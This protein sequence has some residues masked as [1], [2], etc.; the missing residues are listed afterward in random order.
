MK[1]Y[2]ECCS[3]V[4]IKHKLGKSLVTG[5]KAGYWEEAAE[6]YALELRK[7]NEQLKQQ[8]IR[9]RPRRLVDED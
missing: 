3:G 9:W 8:I 5:H 4:A 1:S 7:E 6:I 2:K